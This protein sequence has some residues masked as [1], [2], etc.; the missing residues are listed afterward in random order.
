VDEKLRARVERLLSEGE[1]VEAVV[2][3]MYG[4]L[5]GGGY[6]GP[7]IGAASAGDAY[8]I[9]LT[10]RRLIAIPR[11][12]RGLAGRITLE[13]DRASGHIDV[14]RRLFGIGTWTVFV[15]HDRELKMLVFRRSR[16]DLEQ[17]QNQIGAQ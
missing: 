8:V 11:S 6:S 13:S 9:A 17:M 7:A 15:F 5:P 3:G 10:N 1:E 2:S 4:T 12:V 14:R 16:A